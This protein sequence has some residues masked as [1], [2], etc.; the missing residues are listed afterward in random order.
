MNHLNSQLLLNEYLKFIESFSKV[1]EIKDG[2]YIS[3]PFVYAGNHFIELC[4]KQLNENLFIIS[5]LGNVLI[6]V[7]S[8][9]VPIFSNKKRKEMLLD[10]IKKYQLNLDGVILQKTFARNKLAQTIH[11]FVEAI[12]SVSDLIYFHEARIPRESIMLQEIKHILDHKRIK[13][14]EQNEARIDGVLEKHKVDF[15]IE[16][17]KPEI[18]VTLMGDNTK[19]L[20]EIWGFKFSDIKENH[21]N[22]CS[23][24]VYDVEV[25][26]WS[27]VSKRIL[28]AKSDYSMPSTD[29]FKL[30]EII[31]T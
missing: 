1:K 23:I 11:H 12:K 25:S 14:E 3:L 22:V 29:I 28:K 2:Y 13:Y 19:M 4:I 31:S 26:T 15:L 24:S 27:E 30:E 9:G 17:G 8:S 21:P 5:D 10:I 20:S 7:E 16:N 18:I 6:E